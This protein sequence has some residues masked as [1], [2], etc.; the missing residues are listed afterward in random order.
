MRQRQDR[1]QW[2]H[3]LASQKW[4]RVHLLHGVA[5]K[6][7]HKKVHA[8][9]WPPLPAF[10]SVALVCIVC[11]GRFGSAP[12]VSG[13]GSHLHTVGNRVWADRRILRHCPRVFYTFRGTRARTCVLGLFSG[14]G[15]GCPRETPL[16]TPRLPFMACLPSVR[17]THQIWAG[18]LEAQAALHTGVAPALC[19][20][21]CNT[22]HPPNPMPK[23]FLCFSWPK[24]R[25]P[26]SPGFMVQVG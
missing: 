22:P 19:P 14:V 3:R 20:K 1:D 15:V 23:A 17:S 6:P 25:G 18:A 13:M 7:R 24:N 10:W 26:E 5:R 16:G 4:L 21:I 11:A 9:I 12:S 8:L 2:R